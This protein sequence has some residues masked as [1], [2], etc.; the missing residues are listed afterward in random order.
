MVEEG[1]IVMDCRVIERMGAIYKGG[2][3]NYSLCDFLGKVRESGRKG[4]RGTRRS[5][6][7]KGRKKER[8]KKMDKRGLNK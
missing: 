6:E 8:E 4:K 1:D 7:R 2:E 3:I 5:K